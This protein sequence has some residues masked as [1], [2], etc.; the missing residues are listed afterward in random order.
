M[1]FPE[2]YRTKHPLE[3]QLNLYHKT[4]DDFGWFEF[5]YNN[6]W[7]AVQASQ[8]DHWEHV[9]VSSKR[10]PTWDE[11]CYVK[12]LFWDDEETVI[13]YHPPKSEYVN[14]AKTCLHLWRYKKDMPRPE[15]WRIGI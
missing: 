7:F 3:K 4:G 15:K 13:Q 2:A 9:S 1:K 10:T 8:D 5:V 11:M 6:K 12:R 14:M